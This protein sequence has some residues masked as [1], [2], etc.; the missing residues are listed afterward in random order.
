MLK[1]RDDAAVAL[2]Y[3]PWAHQNKGRGKALG[4]VGGQMVDRWRGNYI[5]GGYQAPDGTMFE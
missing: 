1:A 3:P 4:G 2:A 5:G